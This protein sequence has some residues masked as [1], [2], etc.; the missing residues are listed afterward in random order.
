M[1]NEDDW[2]EEEI[3]L[4]CKQVEEQLLQLAEEELLLPLEE[5]MPPFS[6]T[7]MITITSSPCGNII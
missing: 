1:K 2:M 4:K 5:D 6:G 7:M 3:Q